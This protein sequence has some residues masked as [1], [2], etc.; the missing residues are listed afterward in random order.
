MLPDSQ[1]VWIV[2]KQSNILKNTIRNK[3]KEWKI[4]QVTE[5]SLEWEKNHLRIIQGCLFTLPKDL[6]SR[7]NMFTFFSVSSFYKPASFLL[8]LRCLESDTIELINA[9]YFFLTILSSQLFPHFIFLHLF[10]CFLSK[11]IAIVLIKCHF[12]F[13]DNSLIYSDHFECRFFL[14]R[15]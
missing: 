3:K 8:N 14:L 13:Q 7:L 11:N 15:S 10:V 9:R 5:T 6:F 1:W 4:A 2:Y 12:I